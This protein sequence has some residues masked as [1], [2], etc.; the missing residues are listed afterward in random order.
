VIARLEET[1]LLDEAVIAELLAVVGG[2]DDERVV[3][4]A[5]APQGVAH[6]PELIVDLADHAVVLRH[7]LAPGAFVAR[8][9]RLRVVHHGLEERMALLSRRDRRRTSSGW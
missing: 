1:E 3:P 2:D 8:R 5:Q 9:R 7:Q 6:A 4:L